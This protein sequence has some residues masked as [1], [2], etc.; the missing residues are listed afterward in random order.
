MRHPAN[1]VESILITLLYFLDMTR[2]PYDSDLTDEQWNLLKP[3][4]E[5][6]HSRGWGRPR[7]VDTREVA[8]AIFYINKTGCQWR[9]LPHDFP[10]WPV[11]FYYNKKWRI[12]GVWEAVNQALV[13]MCRET[14]G[15]NPT[16]SAACIDCQSV[17]GTSES[18]GEASGF[19]GHKKVKG[20]KRHIVTDVMGY[21]L[22]AKVHAANEAETST[23]PEVVAQ[24]FIL[25][26]TIAVIFADLGYKEGFVKWLKEN[27]NIRTEIST[28]ESG[29]KPARKRWVVERTFAWIS[30]QRR[31]SRDYER[32]PESSEGMIYV[33]M[34]R[35]LLKQLFPIPNPWRKGEIWSPLQNVESA[36]A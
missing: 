10:S 27:F 32:T 18:G 19:D 34:I 21:V 7:K 8:N 31:M 35:I 6:R 28:K 15:R 5:K 9:S 30:R 33:A 22:G 4:L 29:F 17:K 14:V 3:Y 12:T 23:A 24:V 20:R 26:T 13:K 2:K 11:V 16:P 1:W 25:Y 36:P